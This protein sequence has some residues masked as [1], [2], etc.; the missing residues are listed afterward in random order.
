MKQTINTIAL[1]VI[2]VAVLASCNNQPQGSQN[3]IATPVSVTELKKGSISKL[4]NTTGTANPT[5]GVELNSQIA[6]NYKL[7]IN[8]KTGKPFKLGDTVNKGQTIIRL[9]DV[10]YENGIAIDS[11]KLSLEIAEQEQSKQKT[12]HEKGGVTLSEMRNTEVKVTN[13]RYDYE[14]AKLN[15]EKMTVKAPFNGVIVNLPH[16]TPGVK[17]EQGKPMVGIMDYAQMY[18]DVNLP[19]SAI[20][21]VKVSQPVFITHYTLPHDTLKGTITELSPAVSMET[22]TFKGKIT[23]QNDKL[24]LRPGMFV[25]AD[26]IVDR[27]DS[28]IV[29]PKNVIQSHRN[30]KYVYIVEKNTAIRRDINTGMEDENNIEILS[31]LDVNDNLVVRGF[32][33]LR[34]NSKVK[35]QR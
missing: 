10:E 28:S 7:Q 29:I 31:G 21:D 25:K 24:K 23:I 6:G 16:Y 26:V 13:A 2:V 20:N 19:E 27:A 5:Y 18:M 33:T 11:K 3:D 32:E 34:E 30:R 15:L 9:T 22:R 12:L 14:N 35:V 8:P 1:S 4:F 17:V